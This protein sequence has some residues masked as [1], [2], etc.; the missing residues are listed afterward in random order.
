M[1]KELSTEDS[2]SFKN[3]LRV[4]HGQFLHLLALV[5]GT[6]SKDATNMRN[7]ISAEERL[8]VTLRFLATGKLRLIMVHLVLLCRKEITDRYPLNNLESLVHIKQ[9]RENIR[10]LPMIC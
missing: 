8:A 5:R 9:S 2:A 7:P 1:L 3:Y 10:V 6:I 4:D